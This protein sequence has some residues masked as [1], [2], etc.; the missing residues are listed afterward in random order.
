MPRSYWDAGLTK[1]AAPQS[2]NRAHGLITRAAVM[3]EHVWPWQICGSRFQSH[4]PVQDEET[5]ANCQDHKIKRY[6]DTD[7]NSNLQRTRQKQEEKKFQ[8]KQSI[9]KFH[10]TNVT[11]NS[12]IYHYQVL[13]CNMQN[14]HQARCL[15]YNCH[16]SI[17]VDC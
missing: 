17:N 3:K 14:M 13:T 16:V 8:P 5:M 6:V 1:R 2:V 12:C 15:R 11:C 7:R 10:A 4:F 9:V